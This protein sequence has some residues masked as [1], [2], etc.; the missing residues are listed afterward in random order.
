[1]AKAQ[2]K[3]V[4]LEWVF[5][6]NFTNLNDLDTYLATQL[7]ANTGFSSKPRKTCDICKIKDK[8]FKHA[9]TVKFRDCTGK[10]CNKLPSQICPVKYRIRICLTLIF[11]LFLPYGLYGLFFYYFCLTVYTVYTV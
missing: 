4:E 8:N 1:M 2:T 11:L 3:I 9:S 10:L 6:K 5:I 7:P